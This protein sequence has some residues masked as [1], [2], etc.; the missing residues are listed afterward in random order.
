MQAPAR[1]ADVALV[2]ADDDELMALV[3]QR[4]EHAFGELVRR[5]LDAVHRYLLRLTG[6]PDDA[7]DLAQETFLRLWQKAGSYRPGT[8]R[9]TTWLHRVAHNITVDNLRR[10]RPEPLDDP[11]RLMDDQADP[12]RSAA[13]SQLER[14]L[15]AAIAA[16]PPSQ[17]AALL[18][19]QVQGFANRDAA[20]IMGVSVRGLESL[21]ARAR[22]SLRRQLEP[23]S[24]SS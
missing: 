7:D 6:S 15:D 3:V 24:S 16:L 22:R 12:V 4:D 20:D 17:R 19:C 8:V 21:L 18:L 23:E 13:S 10:A 2:P 1:Q 9:L 5:H 11:E 14:R